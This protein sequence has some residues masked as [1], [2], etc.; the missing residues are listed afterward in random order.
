MHTYTV[1]SMLFF[2][3]TLPCSLSLLVSLRLMWRSTLVSPLQMRM[4][5]HRVS[6]PRATA[7]ELQGGRDRGLFELH[8]SYLINEKKKDEFLV[9]WS[10]PRGKWCIC[11]RCLFWRCRQQEEFH[12]NSEQ[13]R[14]KVQA[15][16]STDFFF[17]NTHIPAKLLI[18]LQI[19]VP[20]KNDIK[21][22]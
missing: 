2:V 3:S 18:T 22:N 6:P 5:C 20:I 1:H 19:S 4:V 12:N 15:F 13:D 16:V 10:A 8:L 9:T 21:L 17:L 11:N 14:E 7:T